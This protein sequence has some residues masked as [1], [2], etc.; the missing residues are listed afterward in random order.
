[1]KRGAL[2]LTLALAGCATDDAPQA[3]PWTPAASSSL[4]LTR[5]GLWVAS[6]DDDRLVLVDPDTLAVMRHVEIPGGPVGVAPVAG[7]LAV[8][9]SRGADAAWVDADGAIDR[10]PLPCGGIGAVVAAGDTAVFACPHDDRVVAVDPDGALRVI[11]APGRPTALAVQP[12]ALVV[13]AARA[14]AVRAL[15]RADFDAGSAASW[16][17]RALVET[18]GFA[19]TRVDA[20]APSD[21]AVFASYQRVDHDSDRARAPSEGTYGRVAD[22]TPRIDPQIDGCGPRYARFDGGARVF[23]G[24]SALAWSPAAGLLWVAHQLTDNVAVLDCAQRGADGLPRLVATAPTGRGPRGIALSPDGRTAWIDAAFDHAITRVTLPPDGPP[25]THTRARSTGPSHLSPPAERGRRLFHDAVD[26]HLTPSGV[27]ACASCHPD[28]GEDGLVWFLHTPSVARKLRRT[29]PAYAARR[30]LAPYH[31]D[32]EFTDAAA[33]SRATIRGLMD[34]DALLVDVDAIAAWLD[35][36]PAPPGRPAADADDAAAITR[37]AAV[38]ESADCADCHPAPLYSDA[39][40]YAVV[41][42]SPDP[43]ARLT[44]VDT[45]SLRGVRARPPY[46]HDG[47]APTLRDAVLA[48][49][50]TPA[51]D[52][53]ALS[54]LVRYLETL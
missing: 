37:G 22:D 7:R 47:R 30:A 24:P 48:H 52:A 6:P 14:G 34:G 5:G 9:L 51:L 26:T 49:D 53:A 41:P 1:M 45:P 46:L 2:A 11:D 40:A 18:P 36:R 13:T 38:F 32:G 19:A 44:P 25:T 29:P 50:E 17:S 28:G 23:S 43:D 35:E 8:A 27:V 20:L 12:D 54:D 16:Q 42:P 21:D 33:L 10:A 31:F 3:T 39:R 4:A 15:D